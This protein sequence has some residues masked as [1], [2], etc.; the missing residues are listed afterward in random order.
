MPPHIFGTHILTEYE[1][2]I[3]IFAKKSVSSLRSSLNGDS[4]SEER[5]YSEAV[6]YELSSCAGEAE[7]TNG[8]VSHD[9][10]RSGGNKL[11][12]HIFGTHIL[13]EYEF[14]MLIFAKKSVS[15][16]RSSLNGDSEQP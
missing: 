16:L 15:S 6:S 4:S 9:D 13:T 14:H 12:P 7:M 11:P 3:L 10:Q 1:F 2:H 5:T 8:Y